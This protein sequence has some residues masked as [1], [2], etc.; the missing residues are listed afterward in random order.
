MDFPGS[1]LHCQSMFQILEIFSPQTPIGSSTAARDKQ[2]SGI[3]RT[4]TVLALCRAKAE[5]LVLPLSLG[6]SL[7]V[8]VGS[9]RGSSTAKRISP[10]I[11][12]GMGRRCRMC[13]YL[14]LTSCLNPQRSFC[15]ALVLWELE[16]GVGDIAKY[17]T[18]QTTSEVGGCTR[19]QT[20]PSHTA[21]SQA[22]KQRNRF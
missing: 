6:R 13:S 7:T 10:T 22:E 4:V 11:L 9:T 8:Q 19:G 15:S 21:I 5:S 3:L 14:L 16:Y 17:H 12:L 18:N 20:L 2:L 1:R